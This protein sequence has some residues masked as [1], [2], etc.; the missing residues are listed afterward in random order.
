[1]P[2]DP[3]AARPWQTGPPAHSS[4]RVGKGLGVRSGP[5]G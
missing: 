5:L 3:T 2:L 1:M 4:S